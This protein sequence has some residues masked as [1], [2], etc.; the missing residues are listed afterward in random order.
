M[1][2]KTATKVAMVC[3][4]LQLLLVLGVFLVPSWSRDINVPFRMV[5]MAFYAG[6]ALFFFALCSKQQKG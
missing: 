6:I 3:S 1:N 2:I 4:A 5:N